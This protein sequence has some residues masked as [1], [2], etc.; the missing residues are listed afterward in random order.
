MQLYRSKPS[1]PFTPAQPAGHRTR[2]RSF[3]F[4][5]LLVLLAP[6]V[7]TCREESE[8]RFLSNTRQLIYEGRR[9][10][11][12]YFSPDGQRLVFQSEREPGN[13][14]YQIYTLDLATGDSRRVSPG[15]GKTT[16]A[17][18]RP[19]SDDILFASTHLDPSSLQKQKEELEFRA[20][21]KARRYSWDYDPA[22]DIFAA[23][24][25]G[26]RLRNLTSAPGY[27]AEGAYSPDGSKIVFCSLRDAYPPEKLSPADRKRLEVDPSWFGEIYI[28]EADGS[29][30]RRLT[31]Q[32]GYDGGP[33]FS[34]DGQRIIW[35]RFD[36][37]GVNA[38]IYT[39][40]LDGS[41]VRR[42]T[43]F[44]AMSWAPYLHPS[45]RYAVFTANKL[46]F[47]NFELFLVD[48]LGKKEP[49]RVTYTDG[50]DGLPVFSPDG[51]KLCWTSNRTADKQ[52]QLFLA[53]WNHEAA[54]QAIASAPARSSLPPAQ[55]GGE[56]HGH[57]HAAPVAE[58]PGS[59]SGPAISET[60]LRRHINRLTA[61]EMNGRAAGSP[62]SSKASAYLS[63][64]LN[65]LG[66][67]GPGGGE[68]H[69]Q[70]F[71]FTASNQ[72]MPGANHLRFTRPDGSITR[73]EAGKDFLPLS[74]S[75][76]AS[77][78]GQVVFAGYGLV[79]PGK[80]GEGYDS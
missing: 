49:V 13:P 48:E 66:I 80:L 11:E 2:G 64:E 75:S 25:D 41:D 67:K 53:S 60:D 40:K 16:C 37:K 77:V 46:G 54:L 27:D 24:H 6:G 45:G 71:E 63:K 55:P 18:F 34:A 38:D 22:M 3:N 35:R 51:A 52:S 21:G 12:G 61:D 31:H 1:P 78:T 47:D 57:P 30:P 56:G 58:D 8:S 62:G 42:L 4:L 36:E 29:A 10:G 68:D 7:G 43:D 33:F 23:R 9:S 65:Q 5:A 28:M 44:A 39:M 74:F 59:R 17:F 14:F 73:F 26:T 72:V 50:F 32:P 76:S 20:S 70:N 69:I 79:V 15:H 19:S